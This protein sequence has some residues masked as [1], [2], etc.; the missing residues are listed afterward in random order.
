[1]SL[2]EHSHAV[3]LSSWYWESCMSHWHESFLWFTS[4]Y[5]VLFCHSLNERPGLLCCHFPDWL[6]LVWLVALFV[7]P[8]VFRDF[9]PLLKCRDKETGKV[10][11]SRSF[12]W[13]FCGWLLA[14][15]WPSVVCVFVYLGVCLL[16]F[17]FKSRYY[18]DFLSLNFCLLF[19]SLIGNVTKQHRYSSNRK[20]NSKCK[21]IYTCKDETV[22][23]VLLN[24]TYT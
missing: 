10:P 15:N 7:L 9:I 16:F 11:F 4:D 6:V 19:L 20:S 3:Y 12:Q 1:M 14:H 21:V 18:T 13:L 2:V 8:E 5:S 22:T 23:F 24:I 17:F